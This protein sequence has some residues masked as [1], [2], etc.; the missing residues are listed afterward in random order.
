MTRLSRNAVLVAWAA[1]GV[2]VL[3]SIPVAPNA[4]AIPG[5]TCHGLPATLTASDAG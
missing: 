4:S 2:A 5:P 1:M 3:A